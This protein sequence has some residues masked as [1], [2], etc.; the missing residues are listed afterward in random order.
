MICNMSELLELA[1]KGRP[2]RL[3]VAC[4]QD[5]YV[6][7]AVLEAKKLGI[8]EPVLVGDTQE[9]HAILKTL[10]ADPAGIRLI[11]EKEKMEACMKAARL[12]RDGEADVI[13]K[14]FVDTAIIM[15]AVLTREN[16]LRGGGI[17]SHDMVAEIRGYDRLIHVTDSAV[18]IAPTLENKA[19]IIRNAVSV[20]HALENECPRVA[21]LCAVEKV[22]EKMPCTA[23]AAELAAMNRRGEI[24][25]CLVDGPLALDNAVSPEAAA[26]KG[27]NSQV[28]GRA[29]ILLA[30]DI[31]AGNI[32]TK[33]MEYFGGAKKAGVIVGAK[34]PV[35]LTS[36]SSTAESKLYTIALSCLIARK[37][38]S[39]KG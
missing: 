19:D 1:K 16:C 24:S 21:A 29:D 22:S 36:R 2:T 38:C 4:A 14:G 11:D 8:A 6:L 9:I 15:R 26:H 3:A 32:L 34:V 18:N 23:E 37:S 13:M 12:I 7:S 33:A 30:P 27:V 35:A 20:A 39:K 17:L 10:G 31:E 28:A 5:E 25:G